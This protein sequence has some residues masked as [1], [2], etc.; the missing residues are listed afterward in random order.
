MKRLTLIFIGI[1]TCLALLAQ[2]DK[3]DVRRGNREFRHGNFPTADIL[4]RR[5][6]LADS[7]SFA[8]RYN[9]AGALY[10]EKNLEEA[11]RQLEVLR[12]AVAESPYAVWWWFNTGDVA[13]GVKDYGKAVEAFR[14][15]L[16]RD[17]D[18]MEAKENYVYARMMLKDQQQNQG[19]QDQPQDQDQNQDQNQDQPQ[20][21]DQPQDQGQ[22]NDGENERKPEPGENGL[23][24]QQVQQLLKAIQAKEQET[25]DKVNREKAEGLRSRQKDKNW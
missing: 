8:A 16:L 17:P 24:P 22:Q 19:Q 15:V 1:L 23:D 3:A 18:N 7:T 14:E 21:Q 20:P 13:L 4:Y 5:A 6:L 10:R 9:L 25:Q 12:P 2:P 11:S